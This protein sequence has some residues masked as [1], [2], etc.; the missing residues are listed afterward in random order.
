MQIKKGCVYV[1]ST[2]FYCQQNIYK[3]GF[4]TSIERRLSQFNNTRTA[5]DNFRVYLK[6]ITINFRKLEKMIHHEL[7]E[8]QLNNELFKLPLEIIENKIEA[9]ISTGCFRHHDILFD[10]ATSY[11]LSRN[12]SFWV[13]NLES[14]NSLENYNTLLEDN[15]TVLYNHRHENNLVY[16]N[17]ETMILYIKKWLKLYDRY[18]L[19][20]FLSDSYYNSLL[21]FLKS[22]VL[23]TVEQNQKNTSTHPKGGRQQWPEAFV[24]GTD[25]NQ[26]SR[27]ELNDLNVNVAAC[28][29]RALATPSCPSPK[30]IIE[31]N[32]IYTPQNDITLLTTLIQKIQVGTSGPPKAVKGDQI[33]MTEKEN[34]QELKSR[35]RIIRARRRCT[36]TEKNKTKE[37]ENLRILFE[38]LKV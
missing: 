35:R 22:I 1:I 24:G 15:S 5:E 25:V 28:D 6:Y 3:I 29:G 36:G 23:T 7:S 37:E 20:Q 14:Y 32:N 11:Q 27:D 4:T 19:Y 9:L 16:F 30:G 33:S 10:Y 18:N 38:H 12:K 21:V 34:K 13:I 2:P 26:D 31:S 8:F 17:D